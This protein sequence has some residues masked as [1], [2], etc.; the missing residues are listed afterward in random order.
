MEI[1]VEV[2]VSLQGLEVYPRKALEFLAQFPHPQQC[3]VEHPPKI[4]MKIL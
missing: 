1:F 3:Q 4:L 2:R